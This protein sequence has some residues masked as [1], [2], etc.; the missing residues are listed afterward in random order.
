MTGKNKIK[1]LKSL[2]IKKYRY[3]HGEYI[4][5]GEKVISELLEHNPHLVKELVATEQWL[6]NS[7]TKNINVINDIIMVSQ[8]DIKKISSFKTSG[9]VIAVL[10]VP[11]YQVIKT[12]I[13]TDVSLVLD[14]VQDPGNLGNI[15]RIADWFGI[16]NIFCSVDCVDCFNPKVIQATMGAIIRI[17]VHY[18]DLKELLEEYSSVEGFS[19]YGTFLKGRSIYDENLD[20]KGFIILGNE[21]KGISAE[22]MPYIESRLVIPKYA[23]NS[24]SI[25][26]LNIAAAAAIVCS[27]FKRKR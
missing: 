9:D 14:K 7:S 4:I 16:N 6:K 19:I 12:E 8:S 11:E 25:E 24:N 3:I 22:Y 13:L 2:K 26:S 1:H 23:Y 5:E 20:N 17:K 27:E 18:L 10:Q 21:S 15:I